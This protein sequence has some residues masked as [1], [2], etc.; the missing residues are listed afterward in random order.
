MFGM[1]PRSEVDKEHSFKDKSG[2]TITIQAGPNGWTVLWAEGGSSYKDYK[3]STDVN[4]LA[5]LDFLTEKGFTELKPIIN[6]VSE[7]KRSK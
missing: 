2:V 5:A 6:K 1:M 7:S 4:Y 3:A